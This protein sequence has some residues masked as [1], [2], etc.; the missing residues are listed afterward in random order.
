MNAPL[1]IENMNNWMNLV[2]S[3]WYSSGYLKNGM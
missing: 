1:Q 2:Y 3:Y